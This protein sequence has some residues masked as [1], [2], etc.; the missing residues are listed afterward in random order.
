MNAI[1]SSETMVV[2]VAEVEEETEFSQFTQ[3]YFHS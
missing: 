1:L 2:D 3:L